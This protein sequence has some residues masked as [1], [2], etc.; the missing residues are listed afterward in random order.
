[1]L[2]PP[3]RVGKEATFYGH[4][5]ELPHSFWPRPRSRPHEL[6]P[7]SRVHLG[8]V[9]SIIRKWMEIIGLKL[10]ISFSM[11]SLSPRETFGTLLMYDV[12]FRNL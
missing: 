2:S 12:H 4:D 11:L 8:L 9:T 1:M 6:W 5:L 10:S 7:R 3:G